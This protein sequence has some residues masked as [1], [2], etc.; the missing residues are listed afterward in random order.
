MKDKE[1]TLK[2][3]HLLHSFL[4]PYTNILIYYILKIN[5]ITTQQKTLIK[6]PIIWL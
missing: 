1:N 5:F 6:N 2:L 3:T 4:M